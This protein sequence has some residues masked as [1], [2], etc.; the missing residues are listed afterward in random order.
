[1]RVHLISSEMQ[2]TSSHR[3]SFHIQA[4]TTKKDVVNAVQDTGLKMSKGD[5][6]DLD[7][8]GIEDGITSANWKMYI[9]ACASAVGIV[10]FLVLW[11]YKR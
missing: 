6:E 9:L 3:T 4:N 5:F 8:L 2:S 10:E 7:A 1:M 11:R